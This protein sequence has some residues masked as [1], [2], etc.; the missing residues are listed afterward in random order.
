MP[1]LCHCIP[2]IDEICRRFLSFTHN[3]IVSD[4][5]LVRFVVR[6]GIHFGGMFSMC[7]RNALFCMKRYSVC[8]DDMMSCDFNPNIVKVKCSEEISADDIAIVMF[9]ME[10]VCIRDG[11]FSV[12]GLTKND[13]NDIL[14]AV[15][16]M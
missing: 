5:D 12:P 7:G 1:M 14:S 13:I 6:N 8:I 15:C 16:S 4:S 3:C 9:L 11:M 10:L 2:I